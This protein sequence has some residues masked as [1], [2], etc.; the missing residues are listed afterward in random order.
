MQ[1][2]LDVD[3]YKKTMLLFRTC[4]LQ[5]KVIGKLISHRVSTMIEC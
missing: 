1:L 2:G 5:N 4:W 3:V